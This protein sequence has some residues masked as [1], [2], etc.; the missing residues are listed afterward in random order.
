MR[1]RGHDPDHSGFSS[2]P[3]TGGRTPRT[4]LRLALP[5]L[6]T[7]LL[8]G[9][10]GL[11]RL[12]PVPIDA[13]VGLLLVVAVQV[14]GYAVAPRSE[15]RRRRDV[16]L[17]T[18]LAT[19]VALPLVALQAAFAREP[20]V[21][22]GRGSAAALGWATLALIVALLFLWG[23]VCW[24]ASDEP[25]EGSFLFAPVVTL[26]PAVMGARGGLGE[27]AAL[28]ALAQ[29]MLVAA[30]AIGVGALLPR[31]MQPLVGATALGAQ[32]VALL[33]L[34]RGPVFAAEQGR[35]VPVLAIVVVAVTAL[36]AVFAPIGALVVRRFRQ[37]MAALDEGGIAAPTPGRGDVARRPASRRAVP[38]MPRSRSSRR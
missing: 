7:A 38:V 10:F 22:L 31:P 11:G 5:C 19:T 37:T 34:G 24:L 32:F 9:A 30:A 3:A 8:A 20:F 12:P 23:I 26:V 15:G 29:A 21:S 6:T 2:R 27:Q 18:L 35:I 13:P 4:A 17:V 28:A 14:W 36:L 25:A 1:E 16:W 33:L